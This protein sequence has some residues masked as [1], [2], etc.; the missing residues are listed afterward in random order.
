MKKI[1]LIA[2][3]LV[4]ALAAMGAGIA[5]FSDTEARALTFNSGEIDLQIRDP[6]SG[7]HNDGLLTWSIGPDWAP[8]DITEMVTLVHNFGTTGGQ[9]YGFKVNSGDYSGSKALLKN[10]FITDWKF[11]WGGRLGDTSIWGD[12]C[13][14]LWDVTD[15]V[16]GAPDGKV[17]LHEFMNSSYGPVIYLEYGGDDDILAPCANTET[18]TICFQFNP[19]A[20]NSLMNKTA[21]IDFTFRLFDGWEGIYHVGEV[22]PESYGYVGME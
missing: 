19:D 12:W 16:G 3:T 13:V 14:N 20:G 8:G 21:T 2:L 4:L 15:P 5:Y 1:G 10:T 9:V 17:S 11:T 7:W 18:T 6:H 22:S